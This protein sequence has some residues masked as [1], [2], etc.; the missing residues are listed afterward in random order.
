LYHKLL[1]T[2]AFEI[3]KRRYS[4][5]SEARALMGGE[6]TA[7][8]RKVFGAGARVTIRPISISLMPISRYG[9]LQ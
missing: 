1:S 8:A 4:K 2:F 6:M 5:A 9:H 7:L 3:N